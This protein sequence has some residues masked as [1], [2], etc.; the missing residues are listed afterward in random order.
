MRPQLRRSRPT[1]ANIAST[2]ALAIALSM[3]GAY[4]HGKIGPGD[5]KPKAVKAKHIAPKAVTKAKLAPNARP[6]RV[7]QYRFGSHNF[8]AEGLA[9]RLPVP[10]RQVASSDWDVQVVYDTYVADVPY[11]GHIGQGAIVDIFE[12]KV[13][14]VMWGE[15]YGKVKGIRITQTI[16]TVTKKAVRSGRPVQRQGPGG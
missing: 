16:P 1:Y 3:G 11:E 15:K 9:V 12:G 14:M 4:A 13:H 10:P 8:G 2:L 7:V 6:A 5:I